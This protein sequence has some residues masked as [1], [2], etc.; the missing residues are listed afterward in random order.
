MKS[1]GEKFFLLYL[2]FIT[3]FKK[4][5]EELKVK[6][7]YYLD[8]KFKQVDRAL[9]SYY[10]NNNPYQISKRFL[11]QKGE[12]Q[13]H[14]YGETP[15]T[16]L[17]E[18][19][20][21]CEFTASDRVVELGCGIG[22]GVFFLAHRFGCS[23]LGIEWIPE[24]VENATR[25]ARSYENVFFSCEDMLQ[26]DLQGANVVYLYGTCLDDISIKAL[27]ANFKTLPK[28]TKI[29]TVSYPLTEYEM[30]EFKVLKEFTVAYPWGK[31]K[32]FLQVRI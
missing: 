17:E 8:E 15:L 22:R 9:L 27:I 31:A 13:V 3:S 6:R 4:L 10:S 7:R 2:I 12:S 11:V 20:I 32:V 29:I 16:S 25:I 5:I 21:E 24:F 19:G 26:C 14:A 30:E 28:G 1:I 23:V 18:I